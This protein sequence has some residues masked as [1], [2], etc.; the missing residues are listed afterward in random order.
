MRDIM[1]QKA[2]I[3]DAEILKVYDNPLLLAKPHASL[4]LSDE[5]KIMGQVEAWAL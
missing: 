1:V 5:P 2:G 4:T 3:D